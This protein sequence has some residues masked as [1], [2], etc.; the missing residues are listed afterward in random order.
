MF[1]FVGFKPKVSQPYNVLEQLLDEVHMCHDHST[2]AVS[3]AS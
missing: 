3:F 1:G 2:T